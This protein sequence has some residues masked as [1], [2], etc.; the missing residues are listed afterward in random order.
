MLDDDLAYVSPW[1]ADPARVTAPVVVLH[2]GDDRIAPPAHGEWLARHCPDSELWLR[3]GEGHISVLGSA[4]QA[5]A[6]LLP[7][8]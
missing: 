4:A 8:S 5:L 1:G 3:E 6:R 7:W 2:G